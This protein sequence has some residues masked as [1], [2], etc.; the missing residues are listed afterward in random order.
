[1]CC[2][3]MNRREF[4]ATGAAGAVGLN[5]LTTDSVLAA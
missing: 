3:A 2:H 5:L 1:M 4:L